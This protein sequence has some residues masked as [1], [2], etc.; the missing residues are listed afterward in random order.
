MTGDTFGVQDKLY[1]HPLG[2]NGYRNVHD[3]TPAGARGL[4][5]SEGS[6]NII[7]TLKSSIDG[8][9]GAG[10]PADDDHLEFE[11]PVIQVTDKGHPRVVLEVSPV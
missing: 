11:R 8:L 5:F 1:T 9:V 2:V 3:A 6:D 4:F 7:A 10:I